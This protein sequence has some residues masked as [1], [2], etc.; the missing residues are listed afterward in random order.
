MNSTVTIAD[1]LVI[2]GQR[3]D[4]RGYLAGSDG[5]LSARLPSGR[6]LIT[7]A[8]A[9]KGSIKA[10]D[11]VEVDPDGRPY[12]TDQP[13]SSEIAMHLEV[14]RSRPD[15]EAC[16]HS[17]APFA[18]AFAVA[19]QSLPTDLL[20]EAVLFVGDIVLTEYAPPG[21]EAVPAALRPYLQGHQA[22]LLRN[23]GLLTIGRTVE[24]A[25]F[26]HETVEHLAYIYHLS[27]SLGTPDRIPADD[28][29]RL[30]RMHF[31]LLELPTKELSGEG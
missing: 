15:I 16:V 18:T 1:Q 11:L 27:L 7:P 21:T 24:E 22:F 31:D 26:R 17:H 5:N 29:E 6:L 19:G 2:A 4:R 20:P 13:A 28:L 12:N 3:L 9:A 8:G 14:Y 23:H 25:L 10:A 30:R